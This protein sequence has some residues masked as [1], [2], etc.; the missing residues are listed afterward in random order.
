MTVRKNTKTTKT[1]ENPFFSEN[2]VLVGKFYV[3][4]KNSLTVGEKLALLKKKEQIYSSNL[5]YWRIIEEAA[6]RLGISSDE[7][8]IKLE[9]VKNKNPEGLDSMDAQ[10]IYPILLQLSKEQASRQHTADEEYALFLVAYLLQRR[11]RPDL[12]NQLEKA[13]DMTLQTLEDYEALVLELPS[14][15]YHALLTFFCE[16]EA[17]GD[18][19]YEQEAK[20]NLKK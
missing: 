12:V 10:V 16:E 1:V 14:E 11:L 13:Y 5:A 7:L 17:N 8:I 2:Y 19:E 4:S 20:N 18:T 9:A 6:T 3:K 15:Q